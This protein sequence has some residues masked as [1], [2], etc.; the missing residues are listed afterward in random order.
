MKEKKTI[1]DYVGMVFTTFGFSV[2]VLNIFCLLF[3]EHARD[4]S[5]MFSM[6]KE[7]LS[8]ATMMQFFAAAVLIVLL[9]FLFF[10]DMVIKNMP[11]VLRTLCMVLSAIGIIVIFIL[12]FGWFPADQWL[13]WLMFFI[14]FGICFS[15]SALVAV[16][17]EKAEN[18]KMEAALTRLKQQNFQQ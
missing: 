1:F 10:T 15:V 4:F 8:V 6:G 2:V 5:S 16:L 11:V 7:G 14:S 17:R 18:K 13:P 3:G 12:R 9:R